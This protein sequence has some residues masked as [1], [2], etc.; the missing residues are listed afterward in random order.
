MQ[1]LVDISQYHSP[2]DSTLWNAN[3]VYIALGVRRKDII[4]TYTILMIK[5]CSELS[6]YKDTFNTIKVHVLAVKMLL[7]H[8]T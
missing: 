7:L 2:C 1:V 5:K 3:S 4:K 6:V 8:R